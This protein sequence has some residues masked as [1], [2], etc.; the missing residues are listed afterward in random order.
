MPITRIYHDS[1]EDFDKANGAYAEILAP[2][3]KGGQLADNDQ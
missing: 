3:P 1:L 2:A